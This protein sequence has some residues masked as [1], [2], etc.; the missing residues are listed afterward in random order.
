M[1]HHPGH[2]I[3]WIAGV[4]LVVAGA[5]VP[6]PWR[7]ARVQAIQ[8]RSSAAVVRKAPIGERLGTN[9]GQ[10]GETYYALEAG[11]VRVT[12]R[13]ADAVA[14]TERSFDGDLHTTLTDA[15]ANEVARLKFDRIDGVHDVVQYS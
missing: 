12:S 14:V 1:Q 5:T 3:I 4:A 11:A 8:A 6:G 2:R 10:K 9:P 7:Q 15:A 13:F